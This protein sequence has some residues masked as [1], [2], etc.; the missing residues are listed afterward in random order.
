MQS[1]TCV[2]FVII[3]LIAAQARAQDGSQFY[4]DVPPGLAQQVD[5]TEDFIEENS[6]KKKDRYVVPKSKDPSKK[7]HPEGHIASEEQNDKTTPPKVELIV[8]S[9]GSM[10]QLLDKGRTKMYYTKKVLE[11]YMTDQWKEKAFVGMRVYGSRKK[12]DCEDNFLSTQFDL[13]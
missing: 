7:P 5:M 6:L 3:S 13:C 11:R 4:G 1:F 2:S 9:S 10:G 8:D 12:N